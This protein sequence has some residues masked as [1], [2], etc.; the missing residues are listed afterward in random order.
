[1][2]QDD[3]QAWSEGSREGTVSD[4]SAIRFSVR[5]HVAEVRI[6]RP[7]ANALNMD[8]YRELR[9][10]FTTIS[11]S[12]PTEIRAAILTGTGKYF[13]AGRDMKSADKDPVEKRNAMNRAAHFAVYHCAVPLIAAVNGAALGGGLTFVLESDIIVAAQNATFG[14]P[15]INI[16]LAGGLAA[17][18]R[19]LNIYQGRKLYF[20]GRSV[21]AAYM[22]TAGVVDTVTSA[23]DLMDAAWELASDIASKSPVAVRAA[24]WSANEI[25]KIL[26]YEQ[27]NRAIQS[28][29]TLGLA[30]TEDHKEAIRAFAE[31]RDPVFKGR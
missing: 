14:L 10:A 27:A 26:D 2:P 23:D 29:V 22:H 15:E 30:A 20:T 16:G 4:Y 17:T 25:E 12:E 19:G 28:R 8:L 5:D 21:D 11:E 3:L 13:C 6:D 24:K 1:V 31:K 18:R 7:P 9:D